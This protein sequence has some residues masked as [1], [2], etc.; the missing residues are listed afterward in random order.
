MGPPNGTGQEHKENPVSAP[1]NPRTTAF[2]RGSRNV[3]EKE[4]DGR[5]MGAEK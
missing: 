1:Q 4:R 3:N 2:I 5:K